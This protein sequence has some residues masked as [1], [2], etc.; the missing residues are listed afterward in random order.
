MIIDGAA[1]NN[2]TFIIGF[3]LQNLFNAGMVSRLFFHD[4]FLFIISLN[5]S[6]AFPDLYFWFIIYDACDYLA[7]ILQFCVWWEIGCLF[8]TRGHCSS[9]LCIAMTTCTANAS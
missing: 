1:V 3:L 2:T 5:E 6:V 4:L 9:L 8:A 7:T